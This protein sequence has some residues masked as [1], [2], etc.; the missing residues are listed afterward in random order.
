[1]PHPSHFTPRKDPQYIKE[2]LYTIF[3]PL[4]M[5]EYGQKH[6]AV[7]G[8]YNIT[9]NPIHLCAFVGLNYSM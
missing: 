9:A 1:M 2:L 3:V 5:G 6:V 4:M 7:S 8:F